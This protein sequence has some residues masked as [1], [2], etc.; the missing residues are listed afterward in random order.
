MVT[1]LSLPQIFDEAEAIARDVQSTF[2]HLNAEQTNWKPSADQ[3][4]VAQC[5]DHLMATNR[6]LFAVFD[7]TINGSKQT[8]LIERLPFLPGFF[9]RLMVKVLAP[10]ARQ[11][12]KAPPAAIPSASALDPGIV[13]RFVA[14]QQ[15]AILKMKAIE[16][17]NPARVIITSPFAGFMTYS[18]LDACRIIIVHERRH[19]AQAERVMTM[20]DFPK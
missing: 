14:H 10:D 19:L 5:L 2:G 17:F 11:K 15:E 8:K 7:Q 4:S 3:W 1:H 20:N 6:E 18:L 13:D 16:K 9:G 12:F